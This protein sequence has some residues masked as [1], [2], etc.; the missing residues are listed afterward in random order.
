[1]APSTD[2]SDKTNRDICHRITTSRGGTSRLTILLHHF[3]RFD[4]SP[5]HSVRYRPMCSAGRT[6]TP[7]NIPDRV[8]DVPDSALESHIG[9]VFF[10]LIWSQICVCFSDL[11]LFV[12]DLCELCV[13]FLCAYFTHHI[14]S[15]CCAILA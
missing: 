1:M 7:A 2:S 5:Q 13:F 15:S 4:R 12:S 10:S 3:L 6:A 8:Y 14:S 11:F 9:F